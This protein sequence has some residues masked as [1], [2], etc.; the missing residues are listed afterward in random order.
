MKVTKSKT[1]QT[2]QGRNVVIFKTNSPVSAY[3]CVQTYLQYRLDNKIDSEKLFVSRQGR[4]LNDRNYRACIKKWMKLIGE[5][6]EAFR[7]HSFRVGAVQ[8]ASKKYC[9]PAAI[10]VQGGW[11]S[12]CFL[13]YARISDEEAGEILRIAFT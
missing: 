11:K 4:P 1:D 6:V 13:R 8:A 9:S 10:K 7:T 3:T 12:N 5:D 2:G